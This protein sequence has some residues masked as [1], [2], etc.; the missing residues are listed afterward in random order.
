M[1]CHKKGGNFQTAEQGWVPLFLVIE[2]AGPP[3]SVADPE[4]W[5]KESTPPSVA[6]PSRWVKELTTIIIDRSWRTE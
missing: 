5:L 6:D 1:F 2:G 3:P 4:G